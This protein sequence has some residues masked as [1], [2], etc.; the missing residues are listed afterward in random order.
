VLLNEV[1]LGLNSAKNHGKEVVKIGILF[2][3]QADERFACR[4]G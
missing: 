4:V 2:A 3:R 1:G